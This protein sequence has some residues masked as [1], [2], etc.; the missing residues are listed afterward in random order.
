MTNDST[1]ALPYF[2][3]LPLLD[4]ADADPKAREAMDRGAQS[5]RMLPNMYRAMAHAPALLD[6]YL[7]GDQRFRR[8]SGFTPQEQDVVFLIISAEN[9][10]EYCVAAHSHIAD[11][12]GHVPTSVTDA[13]RSGEPIG[14]TRLETLSVFTQHM[15]HTRGRPSREA[16]EAFLAAGYTEQHI[17]YLVLA[18][19][20]KMMSNYTNHMFDYPV[21]DVFLAREWSAD[22]RTTRTFPTVSS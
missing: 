20:V 10:C 2:I 3:T 11:T 15:L 12:S 19:A 22:Q 6:T 17:L 16:T 14:D 5:A 21:D 9:G 7:I 8:E 1:A 13:I 18:L 4:P